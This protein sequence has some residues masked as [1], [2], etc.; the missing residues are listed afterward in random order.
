MPHVV[1]DVDSEVPAERVLAAATD[2]SERRP[3][4]WP[5]ISR[6]FWQLHE[7]GANWAEA[8]EGSPGV[9]ARERYEWSDNRVVGTTQDSN[10]FQPGGTWT[11]AVEPRD[12]GGSHIH[13][14][15]DRRF[16]GKGWLFYPAVALF[17][18]RMFERN[19]QKTLD[20]LAAEVRDTSAAPSS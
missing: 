1:V 7:R 17:G 6:E 4:L 16:K 9:W 15:L 3:E 5:N 11:L 12:G 19:L 10:V 13:L 14:V 20:V 18:R 8:T 2:F